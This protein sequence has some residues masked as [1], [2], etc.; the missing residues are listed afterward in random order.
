MV[1]FAERDPHQGP[2]FDLENHN[3]RYHCKI[4]ELNNHLTYWEQLDPHMQM[5]R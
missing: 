4:Y 1:H 3:I 5:V 2:R